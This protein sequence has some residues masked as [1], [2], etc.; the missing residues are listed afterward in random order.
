[1]AIA[2]QLEPGS[3][4]RPAGADSPLSAAPAAPFIHSPACT[5]Y[6]AAA[7]CTCE[8]LLM[9]LDSPSLP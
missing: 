2:Q 8:E 7:E 1:V 3:A 5:W 6:R 9:I 4:V